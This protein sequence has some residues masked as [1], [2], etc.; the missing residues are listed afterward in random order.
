M[1]EKY[2]PDEW[3]IIEEG[4]VPKEN[5]LSESIFSLGNE[6]MGMRGFFE[7][8]YSGDSLQGTYI[9]GIYY[10]DKTRVGWWKN[11]YPEFFAKVLNATNWIGINI[12]INGQSLD[13]AQCEVSDF[14]RELDM[15]QGLLTRTFVAKDAKGQESSVKFKR[16]LSMQSP[17]IACI[18]VSVTPLNY[19][20]KIVFEPYLD[21]D[22]SNEDS[23]YGEKFW[24]P[25][26]KKSN[27]QYIV[28]TMETKKTA[29]WLSTAT[30]S[31]VYK[32]GIEIACERNV[33]EKEKYISTSLETAVNQGQEISL[34]K[35]VSVCTSRDYDK[36]ELEAQAT[37]LLKQAL[38]TGYN[39]LFE[40]HCIVMQKKWDASDVVIEGDI[41]AQQGIRY[42]IFQ[43]NQTYTGKDPRLNIGPKGFTGE[44]YGGCT[45]WDTEA[46][47]F[48]FYL[49]TDQEVAKN[50]LYYRYLHLPQAKENAAKLGF[51]GA[52]YPMVTMDGQE[53]HNEWEITFEEIHRNGAIAYAIYNYTNYT[54]DSSYLET[55]GIEVLV[56]LCRFWADRVTYQPRK[57]KYMILGVTG[58][59]EYENN[60]NNNWYTNLMASWTLAYTLENLRELKIK[61]C[62]HYLEVVDKLGLDEA[63][64]LIWKEIN[65]KMY[66]PT[67]E[68][69]AI[70]EQNDLYMDKEQTLV[71]DLPSE[72]LPLNKNWSWDRILRSCFIKQA[73]VI[74]GIYFFPEQFDAGCKQR[75]FDFYE[76]RTVHESSLSPSIYAI[77]ACQI[78]YQDKAHE[79]YLRTARLDLDNY[80]DDTDDGVHLTSMV[81][82]WLVLIQGF[83]GV[84]VHEN[85][86]SFNPFVPKQWQ[87]Y[88][89]KINFRGRDL[90]IKV[91]SGQLEISQTTGT[92]MQVV[93]HQETYQCSMDK[94]LVVP[95]NG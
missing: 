18:H 91:D 62:S 13:L 84:S 9:A 69:L 54:G 27:E 86:L 1:N 22:I 7:E 67:V 53:C 25:I 81:G 38:N 30:E 57:D 45:Y 71:S 47:C 10:P 5:R 60:V 32:D 31:K 55:Y 89:F 34:I 92:P 26:D 19:G 20:G 74:Q 77:V 52:L 2:I 95:L 29:F 51:K 11:G 41:K 4:F 15:K 46:F 3:K 36:D 93:V 58:P 78:G 85:Q 40:Q 59:N 83:A 42:N 8:S 24:V 75:N 44:K 6:H 94:F 73:D 23:N 17:H 49:Y 90:K 88:S 21:G 43:L 48:P 12:S 79:M 37:T 14:K 70:F 56:E 61:A 63:E 33:I 65:E 68:E 72:A 82:S 35:Y 28:L 87:G 80:N 16:F 64:T 66:F 50:L 39:Q 76:P